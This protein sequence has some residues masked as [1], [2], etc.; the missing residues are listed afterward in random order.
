MLKTAVFQPNSHYGSALRRMFEGHGGVT[1]SLELDHHS[2]DS[3]IAWLSKNTVSVALLPEA[4]VS[5]DC[6]KAV[7]EACEAL[8]LPLFFLSSHEVFGRSAREAGWLEEDEPQ[9]EEPD[10]IKWQIQEQIVLSYSRSIVLRLP[11]VIDDSQALLV[12]ICDALI[13]GETVAVSDR[14]R[15]SLI[16]TLDVVRTVYAMTLQVNCGANNWGVFHLRS[17]DECSEAEL[18]ERIKRILEKAGCENLSQTILVPM[19]QRYWP[20]QGWLWGTRCTD[21]F[22]VQLR[23]WRKGLKTKTIQWLSEQVDAKRV[24]LHPKQEGNAN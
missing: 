23:S 9:S 8:S 13:S 7:V 5:D 19:E 21:E 10:A 6:C 3:L 22:G 24:V 14:W 16:D 17:N 15:G 20:S 11:W 2:P 18:A 4:T 12:K 1:V